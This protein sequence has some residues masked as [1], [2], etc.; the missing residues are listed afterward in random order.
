[1]APTASLDDLFS[2]ADAAQYAAKLGIQD[3]NAITQHFTAPL[4]HVVNTEMLPFTLCAWICVGAV[5]YDGLLNMEQYEYRLIKNF[6]PINALYF[7][8]K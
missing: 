6:K 8:L 3:P 4:V 1:M 7:I 2:P 5:I